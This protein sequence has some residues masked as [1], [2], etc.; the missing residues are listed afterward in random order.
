MPATAAAQVDAERVAPEVKVPG[1]GPG[2][3]VRPP[4]GPR[5][6]PPT[7]SK[8]AAVK[9]ATRTLAVYPPQDYMF[10]ITRLYGL[11]LPF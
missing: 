10:D 8:P 4:T 9:P 7:R 3:W 11:G 1:P 2:P 6:P 5:I